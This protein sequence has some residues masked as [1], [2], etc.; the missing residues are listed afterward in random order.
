MTK[1]EQI[2]K[3]KE[4]S[5]SSQ[6]KRPTYDVP[7]Y[8]LHGTKGFFKKQVQ[9]EEGDWVTKELDKDELSVVIL[10]V[11][12]K[13]LK[14]IREGDSNKTLWSTEYNNNGEKARLFEAL[15]GQS[16]LVDEGTPPELRERNTLSGATNYI[17]YCL[18]DGEI[19]RL[20]IKGA[21]LETWF[22]YNNSLKEAGEEIFTVETTVSFEKVE[23]GSIDYYRLSFEIGD[24]VEDLDAIQ[25]M[26]EEINKETGKIDDFVKGEIEQA[27]TPEDKA[28]KEVKEEVEY[29]TITPD[30]VPF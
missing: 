29:E 9:D 19:A 26:M 21:G 18:V 10:K 16:K 3:M 22:D 27:G 4:M 30:D 12:R 20:S 6:D 13:F 24:E 28:Q 11:R 1:Q 15:E 7:E 14:F 17:I 8:K 23:D 2:D 25:E 5:G